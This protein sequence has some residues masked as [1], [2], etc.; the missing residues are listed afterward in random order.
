V[1]GRLHTRSWEDNDKVKHYRT[2][3]VAELVRFLERKQE[4]VAQALR[5]KEL[6][7]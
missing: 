6:T 7:S 4:D 1:E 3:V 2:E 5:D